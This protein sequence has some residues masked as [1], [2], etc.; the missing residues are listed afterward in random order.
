MHQG[1]AVDAQVGAVHLDRL[2]HLLGRRLRR[3]QGRCGVRQECGPR[4]SELT[5]CRLASSSLGDGAPAVMASTPERLTNGRPPASGIDPHRSP[6]H[7]GPVVERGVHLP[8]QRP[9]QDDVAP[10][11]EE[12]QGARRGGRWRA[13]PGAGAGRR[14]SSGAG[15]GGRATRGS[16]QQR[17]PASLAQDVAHAAHGVDQAGGG[18]AARGR[19]PACCAG[20]RRRPP[21]R[22]SRPRSRS[23]TPAPGAA[24]GSAPAAGGA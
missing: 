14:L 6:H 20:S 2:Q 17:L 19:S 15:R 11:G 24:R 8:A 9:R 16:R 13:G 1:P 23:P 21:G 7:P 5:T 3:V 22:A 10:R 18:C 4:L 12:Q